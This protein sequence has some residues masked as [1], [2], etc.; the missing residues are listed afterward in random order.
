MQ[1]GL[2]YWSDMSGFLIFSLL[3]LLVLVLEKT[4][5]QLL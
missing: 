2:P 4:V 3:G 5:I 1:I